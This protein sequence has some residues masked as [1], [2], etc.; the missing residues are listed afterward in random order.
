VDPVPDPLLL[1]KSGSA[2]N[3]NFLTKYNI[4]NIF[5]ELFNEADMF[6]VSKVY[7]MCKCWHISTT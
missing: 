5:K 4:S 6:V 1:R 2:K 7:E 3:R